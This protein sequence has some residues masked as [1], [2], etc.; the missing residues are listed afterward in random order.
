MAPVLPIPNCLQKI[1]TVELDGKVIKLQI[2]SGGSGD[3]APGR[4][5]AASSLRRHERWLQG[6]R[7]APLHAWR[8]RSSAR[9]HDQ[10]QH[11][12]PMLLH[13]SHGCSGTRRARS[14][15]AP[16]PAATTAARTAS[17]SCLM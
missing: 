7:K 6:R 3:V 9:L 8:H 1:R 2:V 14:A 13:R 15:S 17:L 11:P 4:G 16:S 10:C 12:L 5:S